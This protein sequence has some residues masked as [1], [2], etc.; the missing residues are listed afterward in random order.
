[1]L[2]RILEIVGNL[3]RLA[4]IYGEDE[5][6]KDIFCY[7]MENLAKILEDVVRSE[8]T[9]KMDNRKLKKYFASCGINVSEIAA[10]ENDDIIV[11]A[12][13]AKKSCIRTV[14][15]E[16]IVSKAL[17]MPLVSA[18]QNRG[19]L[20]DN[21]EEYIFKKAPS[22]FT[23]F[24]QIGRSKY[25]NSV[26]G[27]NFTYMQSDN[28]TYVALAD[29]MGTG[30]RASHSSGQTLEL[31]ERFVEC[32]FDGEIT[33][34]MINHIF[35]CRNQDNPVTFDGF[36]FDMISGEGTFIKQ[37]AAAS[38]IKT[39]D[40]VKII[41]PSSLPAG[42]LEEASPD[43]S[44]HHFSDGE[45]VIMVSDGVMDAL[46]FFDKEGQLAKLIETIEEH[47]PEMMAKR[48]FEEIM[49]YP[50]EYRRDDMTILVLGVWENTKNS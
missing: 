48:L 18:S 39:S 36:T 44:K 11:K 38:F 19:V 33:M 2:R 42:V 46:P 25:E 47:N 22:Y 12:S 7:G 26:S 23:L 21:E 30:V 27:D 29:G 3:K 16:K 14:K 50:E 34:K 28:Y 5:S 1:M 15:F 45:Y 20:T 41:R 4:D 24:G 32:G 8:N 31:F 10:T 9:H 35:S 17:D 49:F 37:G 13:A 40:G 43:V 6:R